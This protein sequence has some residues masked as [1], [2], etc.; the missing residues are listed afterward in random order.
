MRSPGG[1]SPHAGSTAGSAPRRTAPRGHPRMRGADSPRDATAAS[2]V[3]PSP[4]ARGRP[5]TG[6]QDQG[7]G[8]TIP[9]CA[10]PTVRARSSWPSR[11]D[12]PRVRGA[13]PNSVSKL[14]MSVGPSPP[15][16]ADDSDQQMAAKPKR[17]SPPT[18][19]RQAQAPGPQALPGAI[20]ACAGPTR[21]R[22]SGSRCGWDHPRMRGADFKVHMRAWI[23]TGPSSHARG[24]PHRRAGR[25]GPAR[26][27]PA[28]A[29]PTAAQLACLA[30]LADHPRMRGAD[31]PELV[32]DALAQGP[33]PPARG[34]RDLGDA[35]HLPL[36][37]IPA[38][39]GPTLAGAAHT[40]WT[41]DHPRMRG[42]DSFSASIPRLLEGPS[43][44]AR[45]RQGDSDERPRVA[46]TIPA[47]AGPTCPWW[48]IQ[49]GVSDHPRM[50]GADIHPAVTAALGE[51]PSPHA[52]GRRPHR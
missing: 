50:R 21:R 11:A 23:D 47:C 12:H 35:G 33:S 28:C 5:R 18:R 51:G 17:P 13:D 46:R 40:R 27:I 44:H 1:P 41:T 37:T 52:R 48:A 30:G 15:A 14:A 49:Q 24:R 9:A 6:R 31:S 16:R 43:P 42:A 10:G 39:A 34:R 20:P 25:P 7:R 32:A 2:R 45:G 19:D 22:S 38:C 4:R 8:G 26:T 36:G 3:G 29:G